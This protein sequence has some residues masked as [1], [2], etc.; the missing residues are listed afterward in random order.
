MLGLGFPLG[1]VLFALRSAKTVSTCPSAF[2]FHG[3]IVVST[4]FLFKSFGL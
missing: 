2:Y 3:F 4:I 1:G